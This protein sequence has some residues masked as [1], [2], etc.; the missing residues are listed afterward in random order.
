M[1]MFTAI[2]LKKMYPREVNVRRSYSLQFGINNDQPLSNSCDG[3][4]VDRIIG[5]SLMRF[6]WRRHKFSGKIMHVV[7]EQCRVQFTAVVRQNSF[8]RGVFGMK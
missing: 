1:R 3:L 4:I 8:Q 7:R 2:L 5:R 6:G